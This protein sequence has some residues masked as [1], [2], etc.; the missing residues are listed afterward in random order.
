MALE[1]EVPEKADDKTIPKYRQIDKRCAEY[2]A[3]FGEEFDR[4][5]K[6]LAR[7]KLSSKPAGKKRGVAASNPDDDVDAEDGGVKLKGRKR[8][9]KIKEED[10]DA[11]EGVETQGMTDQEM[12]SI[13]DRGNISK[14]SVAALKDFLKARGLSAAG[15]KLELVE[16]T[17]GYLEKKGL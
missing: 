6:D 4:T 12:A 17:Q 8:A 13:S 16:R 9:K 5:Y 3:Q 2:L 14:Q 10:G 15:K 11:M 1:E 7:S